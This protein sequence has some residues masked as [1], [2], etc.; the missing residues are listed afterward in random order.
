M[1][2]AMAEPNPF[3]P[4]WL[5]LCDQFPGA[6]AVR[7]RD[8]KSSGFFRADG[9]NRNATPHLPKTDPDGEP[10]GNAARRVSPLNDDM[11]NKTIA[12]FSND[13]QIIWND[14]WA[15]AR[16]EPWADLCD[17]YAGATDAVGEVSGGHIAHTKT[18]ANFSIDDRV[19]RKGDAECV[20][21]N[22]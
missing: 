20:A 15:A 21:S 14:L 18:I 6:T 3:P 7:P 19:V 10:A 11:Q 4:N 8:G 12:N 13:F 16:G 9:A 17:E 5:P 1:A 22:M 2:R